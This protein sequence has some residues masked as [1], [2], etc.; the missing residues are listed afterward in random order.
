MKAGQVQPM[1]GLEEGETQPFF[2]PASWMTKIQFTKKLIQNNNVIISILSEPNSGKTTFAKILTA[3]LA[4][5]VK[6]VLVTANPLFEP[7][8]LM[9]QIAQAL[10]CTAENATDLVTQINSDAAHVLLILDDAHFLPQAFIKEL[11]EALQKL[12]VSF[13]H[14]ALV[15]NF[16]LT[17]VLNNLSQL[18]TDAI[19]SIELGPLSAKETDNL[20]RDRFQG[21][22]QVEALLTNDRVQQF[23]D[24]TEGSIVG[25]NTQMA[26]FFNDPA[27]EKNAIKRKKWVM[28]TVA[29]S[30]LALGAVYYLQM[31]PS[32]SQPLVQIVNELP[33]P[34]PK[35]EPDKPIQARIEEEPILNS[36]IPEYTL[37][38]NHQALQP[39]SLRKINLFENSTEG[40]PSVDDAFV[41]M[42]KV[43]VIPK[44]ISSKAAKDGVS[45]VHKPQLPAAPTTTVQKSIA[46]ANG[47]TIQLLASHRRNELLQFAKNHHIEGKIKIL[48]AQNH[49]VNW[50]V[51]T[52]GN[53]NQRSL[54]KVAI[55]NLPKTLAKLKP[56]IRDLKELKS[57]G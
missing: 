55:N 30:I 57:S 21:H 25:I 40:M 49:G 10:A 18:Y 22:P 7:H 47:Y 17:A 52:Y 41:V 19:H 37:A 29:A 26:A 1:L 36:E 42:D 28:P 20:L 15:A 5:E 53:Y 34:S 44:V 14:I 13:L 32:D 54:A 4:P 43:I 16:S 3:S 35:I 8:V 9:Q 50:Y 2:K 51:L 27:I 23:F 38:A 11:V 12:E 45:A 31:F 6:S 48:T 39:T 33:K 56:W 24:L 46:A